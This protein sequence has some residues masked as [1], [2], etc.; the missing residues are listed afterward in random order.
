MSVS[1]RKDNLTALGVCIKRVSTERGSTVY[2][3]GAVPLHKTKTYRNK[4]SYY[5]AFVQ[6]L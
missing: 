1:S 2:H 4:N 3:Y 6:T 5:W